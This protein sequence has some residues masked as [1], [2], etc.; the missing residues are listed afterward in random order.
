MLVFGIGM[1]VFASHNVSS[2]M[3]CVPL[4][5]KGIGSAFRTTMFN[6]GYLMSLSLAVLLMSLTIP[7]DQLTQIV[8]SIDPI[9]ISLSDRQLFVEAM[10]KT[11]LGLAVLNTLAII[12]SILRGMGN[13]SR[14]S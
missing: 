9:S 6:V 11:C 7:Y 10:Q 3:R 12:P 14:S 2:I 1:G 8:T 5:R 13:R 4:E